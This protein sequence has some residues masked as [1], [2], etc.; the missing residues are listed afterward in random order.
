MCHM[1]PET[2]AMVILPRCHMNFPEQMGTMKPQVS[3]RP[4]S[5]EQFEQKCPK[6]IGY[7]I[8]PLLSNWIRVSL[9]SLSEVPKRGQVSGLSCRVLSTNRYKAS[10]HV[11]PSGK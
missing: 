1:A 9:M 10:F 4:T 11:M 6:T 8:N 2:S 7:S 3:P 5:F